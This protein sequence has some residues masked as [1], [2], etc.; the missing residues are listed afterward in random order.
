M[1]QIEDLLRSPNH[2]EA[3]EHDQEKS[4]V[5]APEPDVAVEQ[6]LTLLRAKM[7]EKRV[8]QAH[9]QD[10]LNW[11]G[12]YISQLF[13][14]TKNLRVNQLLM[15][16]KVLGIKPTDFLIEIYPPE[17]P[18]SQQPLSPREQSIQV[19]KSA[20]RDVS[21]HLENL[22]SDADPADQNE[23]IE[24]EKFQPGDCLP[25]ENVEVASQLPNRYELL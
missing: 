16:L 6:I 17:V 7:K 25:S 1:K 9:I 12:S 20:L 5:A 23:H 21:D 14:K 10:V 22:F 13:A 11:K 2:K 18:E 15:I 8:T 4:A 24:L 19:I 3:M